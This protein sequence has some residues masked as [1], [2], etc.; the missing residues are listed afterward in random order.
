MPVIPATLMAFDQLQTEREHL[1]EQIEQAELD[2]ANIF[3]KWAS[4]TRANRPQSI[5]DALEKQTAKC[6]RKTNLLSSRLN[7]IKIE[8]NKRKCER[9]ALN[10]F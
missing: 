2:Y 1:D 4:A 5:L 9:I 7:K 3:T 10:A 8:L 6:L